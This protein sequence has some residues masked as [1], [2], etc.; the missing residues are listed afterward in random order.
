MFSNDYVSLQ[1]HAQF[2]K[3]KLHEAE[4]WHLLQIFRSQPEV[5]N[6]PVAAVSPAAVR[7]LQPAQVTANSI[8]IEQPCC[9]AV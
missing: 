2:R 9:A 5:E 6:R 4:Q 7:L 1:L 8:V 3:E